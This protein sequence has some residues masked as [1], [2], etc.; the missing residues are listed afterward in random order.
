GHKEY[1]VTRT[2]KLTL[3]ECKQCRYQATVTSGT[4]MEKTRTSLVKWFLAIYLVA[5]DKRGISAARLAS[6]IEVTF[7]TALLMLH[8]IC[9]AMGERDSEYTLAGIVELDDAFF[10]APTEGGKRG[11]GTEKTK[12][13]VGLSL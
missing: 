7:K 6:E 4:V 1:F 5:H 10:G 8:K 3:Y 13:L 2:R 9:R 11:R 12:V